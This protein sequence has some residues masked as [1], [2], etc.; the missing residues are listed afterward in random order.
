M[1]TFYSYLKD[2][3]VHVPLLPEEKKIAA[4]EI[5]L[6]P[7]KLAQFMQCQD[8]HQLSLKNAL[9]LQQEKAAVSDIL[10]CGRYL[11]TIISRNLGTKKDSKSC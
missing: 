3:A 7:S 6:P 10:S 4:G 5:E 8:V 11:F 1:F 9:A 2:R